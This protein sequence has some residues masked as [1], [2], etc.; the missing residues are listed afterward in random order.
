MKKIGLNFL[1]NNFSKIRLYVIFV[2]PYGVVAQVV[3]AQ[4]S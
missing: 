3:R 2:D 4:D 1:K